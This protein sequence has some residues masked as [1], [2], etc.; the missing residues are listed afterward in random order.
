MT[1]RWHE[2]V[3]KVLKANEVRLV[4]YIPDNVLTALIQAVHADPWFRAI[5]PARVPQT[6]GIE[7]FAVERLED[8]EFVLAGQHGPRG[9]PRPRRRA[10]AACAAG[11][12]ARVTERDP[13]RIRSRFMD[14]LAGKG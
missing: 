14:A 6:L 3:V 4:T 10:G 12:R 1:E 9:A 5:C 13:T 11:V 8:V 2:R 7:H